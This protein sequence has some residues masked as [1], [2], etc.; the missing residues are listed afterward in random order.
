MWA[1]LSA[2]LFKIL[3]P[4]P[5]L[6]FQ[7]QHQIKDFVLRGSPE[8]EKVVIL[9]G[10]LAYSINGSVSDDNA[11]KHYKSQRL[12]VTNNLRKQTKNEEDDTQKV[13]HRFH[14]DTMTIQREDPLLP[15]SKG[16]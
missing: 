9:R 4:S 13:T 7:R 3:R 8:T 2:L 10:L 15:F 12:C 6:L 14:T 11:W 5:D 16:Y 1:S